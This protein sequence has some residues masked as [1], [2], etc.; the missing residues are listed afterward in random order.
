MTMCV[1]QL[2]DDPAKL[3]QLVLEHQMALVGRQLQ[4]ERFER[5]VAQRD[6]MIEQIKREAAETIEKERLRHKAEMEALLL[7]F[8]GHG[9]RNERFIDL[10]Q[11]VLFG[12]LIDRMPLDVKA[13]EQEAGQKF[14][15]RRVRN[16]DKHGRGKL[17]AHLPRRIVKHDLKDEE[18]FDANGKPLVFIGYD[19]TERIEF[20]PGSLFVLEIRRC[21]YAP[22]DYQEG[23]S[24]K[25]VT[26][27]Q[28]AQAIEK[29]LPGPGLLAHVIVSKLV[30]HLPLYR[31]ERI[32]AR[33]GV[34]IA[35]STMCGWLMA[36]AE[37]V[38]P[39]ALLIKNRIKQ[40]KA[41]NGDETRLPQQAKGKCI[42]ARI[43]DW[44]GD[45]DNPYIAYAY[46]PDRGGEWPQDWLEGFG[47]F[48]QVDAYSGYEALFRTGKI[49]EVACWAHAR[50][51][52]FKAKDTDSVRSAQMLSMV[53]QLYAVED[54]AQKTIAAMSNPNPT[55][56]QAAEV[57]RELRQ[58]KSVPVLQTIK[59]W[60]D[61]QIKLVLPRSL[62]AE[63]INYT[64]NQWDALC[65]Y[66]QHGILSIDNN[67]SERGVKP[68]AIGRKNWLFVHNEKFGKVYATLMT[69]VGS[70]LRHGLDPE[71]YLRSVLARI[72]TTPISQLDQFLPDVWKKMQQSETPS[73]DPP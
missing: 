31:Q 12:Q 7:K 10:N 71:A 29:G 69:L 56:E 17:P 1:D 47:G 5:E 45:V 42:S 59:A 72:A 2:P 73:V 68:V 67:V 49:I 63:A 3:K 33:E 13:I 25:V 4:I 52:F 20:Q 58:R 34:H 50:R 9:S 11:L 19:V 61:E 65:V 57:R 21:K 24:A 66:A 55:A 38:A 37:L 44:I 14:K 60:L 16:R 53:Q 32:F 18:K 51:R 40:S 39:L 41:L 62:M 27:E 28:P 64:L 46:S 26:A 15:T 48:L 70:A 30:D 35:Q 23:E 8:Y 54:E 22:A 6:A 36:A 43:W